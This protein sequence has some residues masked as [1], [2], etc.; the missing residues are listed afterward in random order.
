MYG[1]EICSH[2]MFTGIYFWLFRVDYHN[3]L[4][5]VSDTVES[6]AGKINLIGKKKIT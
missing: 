3:S 5:G 6:I 1:P 4:T 2:R